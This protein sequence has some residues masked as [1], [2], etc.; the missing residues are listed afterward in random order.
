MNEGAKLD[1]ITLLE[2]SSWENIRLARL[3]ELTF[4]FILPF[5]GVHSFNNQN[6]RDVLQVIEQEIAI[7]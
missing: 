4:S 5:I 1:L 2:A 3:L 6:M 7:P